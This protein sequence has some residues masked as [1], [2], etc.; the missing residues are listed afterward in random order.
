MASSNKKL[1]NP[2]YQTAVASEAIS[3]GDPVQLVAPPGGVV[4]DRVVAK[5]QYDSLV[6][7]VAM[8]DA[9]QGGSLTLYKD[10]GSSEALVRAEHKTYLPGMRLGLSPN[11]IFDR[12]DLW[13][14]Q[15]W[16]YAIEAKT[17][18]A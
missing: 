10:G 8:D 11:G 3:K 1:F 4:A 12:I 5:C 13:Y 15:F 7:G 6:Y 17:T 14:P 9:I 16:A 2:L 18:S